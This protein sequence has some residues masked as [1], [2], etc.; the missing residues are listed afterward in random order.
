MKSAIAT[1]SEIDDIEFAAKELASK[2]REKLQFCRNSMG[3]AFC[4]AE[5]DVAKLGELLHEALGIDIVGLTT[6][7]TI[8]RGDGYNDMGVLFSVLTAD[9]VSFSIGST[10]DLDVESFSEVIQKTYK[11]TRSKIDEEPKLILALAPYIADLTSENYLEILDEASGGIPVFGGVATDHYDLQ[12][13]KTLFNDQAFSKGLVFILL[14][15]NVKPVFSMEHHFGS[16]VEKKGIITKS[17]GN[18]VEKVGDQ[19]FKEFVDSIVPVPDEEMVIYHFQSTPF[20]MELPDYEEDEQPVVRALCTIDHATGAGGFL[21][22]M[23]ESS[24]IYMNVFQRRNLSESCNGAVSKLIEAMNENK[25][26]EYCMAFISTCNARHLLMGDM[27]NLESDIISEKFGN[28]SQS[29]N[30]VGFYGFGEM[31]P[32]GIKADGKAKNRFHNISFALCAI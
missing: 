23:P 6:T 28:L 18:L 21:S 3:I 27:K 31:C 30:A 9:D 2:I 13:Q 1:T 11:Q 24:V 14:T 10:G 20:V 12:Y 22:K 25:G 16:K 15:G 4:D 26:Y 5:M 7:A 32:T 8:E 17:S 29:L 19:T